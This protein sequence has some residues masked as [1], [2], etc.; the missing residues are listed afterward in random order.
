M[1]I[2]GW[3]KRSFLVH[4]PYAL[5]FHRTNVPLYHR[6]TTSPSSFVFSELVIVCC[7]IQGFLFF[8][9]CL[10]AWLLGCLVAWLLGCLVAWL[11]GC[12]VAW[13]PGCLVAWLLGCLVAW[14]LGCLVAWLPGCLVAWLPGCLVAWLPG[15]LVSYL[16]FERVCCGR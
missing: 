15:C 5:Y 14:L 16:I 3:E 6:S 11:P 4:F 2:V 9:F 1:K 7:D 12:L 8:I 10:V 13:L